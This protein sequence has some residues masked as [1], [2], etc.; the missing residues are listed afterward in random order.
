MFHR[1]HEQL[2]EPGVNITKSGLS[3]FQP[4]HVGYDG[5][6]HLPTDAP[7]QEFTTFTDFGNHHVAGGGTHHLYQHI[8]FNFRP[9]RTKVRIE[10]TDT[11][12]NVS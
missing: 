1:P 10:G 9:D 5:A 11:H 4:Q 7:Y 12:D 8:R 6:V 3:G 2:L